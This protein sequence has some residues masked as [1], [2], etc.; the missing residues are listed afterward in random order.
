MLKSNEPTQLERCNVF[1][2]EPWL[3]G[4]K[5]ARRSTEKSVHITSW[6]HLLCMRCAGGDELSEHLS[7]LSRENRSGGEVSCQT[8]EPVDAS[9]QLGDL[10]CKGSQLDHEVFVLQSEDDL[11]LLRERA[12]G[13]HPGQDLILVLLAQPSHELLDRRGT[14]L[15]LEVGQQTDNGRKRASKR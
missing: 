8:G 10:L 4:F 13:I 15:G 9:A 12:I 6:Y 1:V 11:Q 2:Q 5:L 14:A 7:S 3:G